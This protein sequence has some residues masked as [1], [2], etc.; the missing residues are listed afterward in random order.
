MFLIHNCCHQLTILGQLSSPEIVQ[1]VN[2]LISFCYSIES[3]VF[4]ILYS[5]F[6]RVRRFSFGMTLWWMWLLDIQRIGCFYLFRYNFVILWWALK[7]F[8]LILWKTSNFVL[9]S[10][11]PKI[12]KPSLEC[13]FL[14]SNMYREWRT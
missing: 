5:I 6:L 3:S 14:R 12:L 1:K 2:L 10:V 8:L 9:Y 4:Q 7:E 11:V 13:F